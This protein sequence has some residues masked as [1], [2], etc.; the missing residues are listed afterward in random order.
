MLK[1]SK[2]KLAVWVSG[3]GTL[4]ERMIAD[5]R[6]ISLVVAEKDCRGLEIAREAG[7]NTLLIDRKQYGWQPVVF[8]ADQPMERLYSK[9]RRAFSTAMA[10]QMHE[11]GITLIAM[12]GF[13]TVLTEE[14]FDNY[15][16]IILNIHPA[17]LPS[18]KGETAVRD[19]LAFGVKVVGS[20][21]HIA[22]A[23]LDAGPI[24]DQDCIRVEP[25]DTEETLHERLKEQIER[26][27]Y[28][29]VIGQIMEEGI[30][31]LLW[32]T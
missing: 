11:R 16:G 4:L 3:S 15:S 25:N 2:Y 5:K 31:A 18:F 17:L 20:T 6:D 8:W 23:E 1:P 14:F 21:V 19:A 22:T 30:D 10:D 7:I 12:A 13:M 27:M 29:R 32:S 9:Q 24:I 28:S 26:P